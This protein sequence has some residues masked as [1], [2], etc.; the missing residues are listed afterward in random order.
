MRLAILLAAFVIFCTASTSAQEKREIPLKEIWALE[1]PGTLDIRELP[2]GSRRDLEIAFADRILH[3]PHF[4][5]DDRPTKGFAVVGVGEAA[6]NE[7]DK[8]LAQGD[9]PA[10]Q[11]PANA[12]VSI[13]F[14]S[15][16]FN[17]YVHLTSVDMRKGRIAIDYVLVPH[18]SKEMTAHLALIPVGPLSAGKWE[19]EITQVQ[20]KKILEEGYKQISDEMAREVVC[21]PFSFDVV[22]KP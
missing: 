10:K 11:M 7:A 9:G 1:M 18:M 5:A 21:E 15:A 17:R 13:V 19:V 4:R 2:K 22:E 8:V 16:F 20:D 12:D 3:S 6:L 14:F